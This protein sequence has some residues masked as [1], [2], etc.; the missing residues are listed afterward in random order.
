M[1]LRKASRKDLMKVCHAIGYK[2]NLPYIRVEDAMSDFMNDRLYVV[3][4]GEKVFVTVSLVEEPN[5]GYTA[6]KRL[7]VLNKRNCGKGL[8][9]FALH[10]LQKVVDSKIGATPWEDNLTMRHLLESEGFHLEYIFNTV[11]C[12]YSKTP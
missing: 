4:E 1:E 7:C 12:F 5:Y 2:T 8:A 3:A 9:R 11:W 10:E 6:I